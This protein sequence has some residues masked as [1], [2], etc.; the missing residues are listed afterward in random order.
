MTLRARQLTPI[1]VD[2]VH[3]HVHRADLS[4]LVVFAV[5][6]EYLLAASFRRFF[7]DAYRRTVVAA[8]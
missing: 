1:L 3:E 7:L 5:Q 4:D 8:T 6:P 2:P